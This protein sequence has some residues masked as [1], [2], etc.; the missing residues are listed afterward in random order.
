[1]ARIKIENLSKDSKISDAE[2]KGIRGGSISEGAY[3]TGIDALG[4]DTAT[5]E[6]V[7]FWSGRARTWSLKDGIQFEFKGS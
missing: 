2:L 5:M 3:H 4:I 7:K 6:G 1:M